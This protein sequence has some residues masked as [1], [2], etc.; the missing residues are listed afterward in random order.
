MYD[1]LYKK[2]KTRYHFL[3]GQVKRGIIPLNDSKNI[4]DI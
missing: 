4:F 2:K 3:S 1:Y